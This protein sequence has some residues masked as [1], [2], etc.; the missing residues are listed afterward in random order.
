MGLL[1]QYDITD[2]HADML[3]AR[4]AEHARQPDGSCAAAG[5]RGPCWD[6]AGAIGTLK[7]AGRYA[8]GPDGQA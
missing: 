6:R 8:A 2:A 7:L 4:I 5:C 3:W 1:E